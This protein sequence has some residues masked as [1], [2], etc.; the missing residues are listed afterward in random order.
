MD[1]TIR[2]TIDEQAPVARGEVLVSW[3]RSAIGHFFSD[4]REE[5]SG[6]YALITESM[7]GGRDFRLKDVRENLPALSDQLRRHPFYASVGFHSSL[8]DEDEED[9]WTED[10]GRVASSHEG[11]GGSHTGLAVD[12]TAGD[13]IGDPALC[14]G[15]VD[16]L[17]E[18][19]D[20]GNPVFARVEHGNFSYTTDL[21]AGLRR[22]RRKSL[23]EARSYLRG[24]SWVTGVPS[25]LAARQGLAATGAFH[26][27]EELR[28]GG[29]LLQASETLAG[30]SD[31][32][33][34]GAFTALAP[35]LPPGIPREDP[36]HPDM[37]LVFEDAS[38]V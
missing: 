3:Y 4:G 26:R 2:A 23:R 5:T 25:E 14:S 7:S 17:A 24:Y 36:A 9:D 21:E 15:V 19:L 6:S 29:L 34:R 27:V 30:Y 22:S 18:A 13:R 8:P 28:S 37:R 1:V 35:V 20:G 10:F 31:H 16:F 33:M 32:A 11:R 12:L 38:G